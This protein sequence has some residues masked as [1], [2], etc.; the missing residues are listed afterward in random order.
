[1]GRPNLKTLSLNEPKVYTYVDAL[2]HTRHYMMWQELNTHVWCAQ[3]TLKQHVTNMQHQNS[4]LMTCNTHHCI[5]T[6]AVLYTGLSCFVECLTC[7][8]Y[9]LRVCYSAHLHTQQCP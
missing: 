4:L 5:S 7:V 1:M 2:H 8:F 3:K 9:S 6:L